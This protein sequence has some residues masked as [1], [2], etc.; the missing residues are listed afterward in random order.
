[1]TV[2][3]GILAG[4]GTVNG[5]TIVQS[6]GTLSPGVAGLGTLTI[7]NTLNL[8][9]TLAVD[10]NKTTG[11][12]DV[13][14]GLTTVTY[15]GTLAVTNLSGTLTTNDSFKL[16]SA[17]AYTGAFA[18]ITPAAP[19]SGLA[20][21]TNTLTTDGIL[22]VA[23]AGPSGPATITNSVSGNTLTLSWPAGQG[24]LLQVQTN[25]LSIGLGTNWVDVPGSTGISSTNITLNPT[26]P[27]VFYRLKY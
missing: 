23:T 15:G 16:F 10:I 7:N 14:I 4:A 11:T 3:G 18:S 22:R 25:S 24:W 27:T 2:A 19:A 21:N 9:G 5:P 1:M 17:T 12:N 13:I 6:G 26:Q 20:W 8:Q